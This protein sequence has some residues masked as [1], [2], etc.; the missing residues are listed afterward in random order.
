MEGLADE[1]RADI[2]AV[3]TEE[4]HADSSAL[5]VSSHYISHYFFQSREYS[6]KSISKGLV[7]T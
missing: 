6:E 5:M 2:I 7:P 1:T 3:R 4:T